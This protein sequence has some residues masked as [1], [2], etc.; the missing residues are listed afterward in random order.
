M[1]R[2]EMMT[3]GGKDRGGELLGAGASGVGLSA[4]AI[5]LREPVVLKILAS[6]TEGQE[7]LLR[8]RVEKARL[9]ADLQSRHVARII[10]IGVTEDGMPYVASECLQGTTLEVELEERGRLPVEEAVRW[11][12]E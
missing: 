8:R 4:R 5:P 9:A 7:A 3:I 1:V 2:A 10:D 6:Y 11:V 12:L